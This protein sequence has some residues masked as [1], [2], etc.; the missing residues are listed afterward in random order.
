MRNTPNVLAVSQVVQE[1]RNLYFLVNIPSCTISVCVNLNLGGLLGCNSIPR[2]PPLLLVLEPILVSLT[3]PQSSDIGQNSHGV[4][5]DF[6]DSG[7]SLVKENCH[8]SRTSDDIDMNLGPITK[9]DKRNTTT[10]KKLVMTSC[11]KIVTSL[12]FFYVTA[13]LKQP[14]NRIP[15]A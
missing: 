9:L 12:P 10:S 4:I 14:G 1:L 8:N 7:Q 2:P 13:N 5:S 6:R 3:H 15:D 11:Q